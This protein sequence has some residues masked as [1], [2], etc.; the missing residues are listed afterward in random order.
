MRIPILQT[1]VLPPIGLLLAA[2]LAANAG[3]QNCANTSVPGLVP[4]NELGTGTYQGFEGGLYPGGV[5]T[6]PF[7]HTVGGLAQA[8]QIVPRDAAGTPS[9]SGR[10]VFLSIGMSNATQEFSRFVQLAQTDPSKHPAVL[11]VDGAQGGQTAATIQNPNANFWTV[12]EQRLANAG[13]TAAQV[14]AVWFKEADAGPTSGFPAYANT[15]REEF[16]AIFGVLKSKYPNLR[17][18]YLAT[19]IYAG[20]ATSML[21]PE[22][23]SYEQGFSCKW[24]IEDQIAGLPALNYD[25]A[26]GPVVAPWID[27]GTYNWANGLVPRDDGLTWACA[28]FQADGTHPATSGREKVAQALLAFVRTDATASSWYLAAPAPHAYGVGKL[29]SIGTTPRVGWTGTPSFAAG[30]FAFTYTDALPLKFGLGFQGGS[31]AMA[32]FAAGTAIRWVGN[33][34][35]RLPIR[36]LDAAGGTSYAIPILPLMIGTTRYYMGWSRDPQHPDGTG[37]VSTDGLRVVFSN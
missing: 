32:P 15:L 26:R 19:R 35:Q 9:A 7:A 27:W 34:L 20:Y 31:P 6:R 23:Y 1:S 11:P 8:A 21:N 16:E 2:L 17:V 24:A 13:A 5:N 14:Q 30:D 37:I 28:D 25:P 12:V 3:A 29:T 36:Q 22:P 4:L 33:P 18:T 10:I